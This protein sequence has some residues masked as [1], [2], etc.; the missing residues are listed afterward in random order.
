M[1]EL[2]NAAVLATSSLRLVKAGA[3]ALFNIARLCLTESLAPGEDDI[4]SIVVA[5]VESLKNI[6]GIDSDKKI[7]DLERLF[8]V[9]LGGFILLGR[10]SEGVKEILSGIEATDVLKNIQGEIVK[11]VIG[12]IDEL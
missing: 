12:L 8:V 11:E 1:V 3:A 5:L 4:I 10:E 6:E 2:F 9:S 7:Q